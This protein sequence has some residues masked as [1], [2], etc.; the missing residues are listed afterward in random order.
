MCDPEIFS[1][2]KI[3]EKVF[4]DFKQGEEMALQ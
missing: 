2:R 1:I 3:G 4:C